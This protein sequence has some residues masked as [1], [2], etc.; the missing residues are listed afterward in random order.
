MT[1]DEL[2]KVPAQEEE[3]VV[4]ETAQE[5]HELPYEELMQ[6]YKEAEAQKRHWREK[7]KKAQ[8]QP[9][10]QEQKPEPQ[11]DSSISE[12]EWKKR[13]EFIVTKGKGLDADETDEV[14]SYAKGKGISYQEALESSVIK[15]YLSDRTTKK[16]V[17]AATPQSSKSSFKS[18]GKTWESM[19]SKEKSSNF[20]EF[21]KQR[22]GK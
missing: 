10:A 13:M 3:Q 17:E 12:D 5:E 7:A 9:P 8:E 4:E 19:S 2:E 6:K 20:E 14:I 1:N 18:N 11:K 21:I 16:R 15:A 22:L